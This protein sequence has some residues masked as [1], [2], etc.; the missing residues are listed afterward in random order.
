MKTPID[1]LA[2]DGLKPS[3]EK[4]TAT[5]S[6]EN[7]DFTYPARPD[8]QVLN[9]VSFE[10]QEGQTVA[11]CGQSGCGK[12]TCVQLIQRFYDP[13]GGAVKI[14]GYD[15]RELNVKYLRELIGVVT[16]EP[17]LFETSVIENIRYG[18]LG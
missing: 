11:L 17:V 16:Q 1:A 3:M 4:I 13:Q 9:K 5:V 2:K 10:A 8:H 6:L 18:R 15:I 7:I 12:S 14:G